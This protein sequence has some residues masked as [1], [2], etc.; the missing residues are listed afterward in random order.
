MHDADPRAPLSVGNGEFAFTA[1]VTG[2][3]SLWRRY[4]G[5]VPL[6]TQS[7][8]GWHSFPAPGGQASDLR[9]ETFDTYGRL[10]GYATSSQG[11][12]TL[13]NW[14]R[15]NPHRLNLGRIALLLDG[16]SLARQDLTDI[17]Q[18]LDLWTG[19]LTS[20]FI[21]Q[22]QP[23]RV[24]TACHPT[25]DA[26]AV[27]ID[28]PLAAS[29]RLAVEFAFPYGSAAMHAS[30]WTA[31][32]KQTTTV[33]HQDRNT[34]AIHRQLD[35]DSYW[36]C[37][38]WN[39]GA[40]AEMRGDHRIVLSGTRLDFTCEFT[41]RPPAAEPVLTDAARHASE[42][43][44]REFWSSG[45]AI[46]LGAST[47]PRAPELERRIVLS[48]YLTAIQCAGST[49]PQETGLTCN[50]W[51]G[52]FHLEMHW[53]HAAHFALW[54]R[55]P[56]LERSLGWYA[57]ILPAA[58]EK[59]KQQGYRGVRWPKMTSPDGRSSPSSIGELLIWQQPHPI[60]LA[61]L[62]YQAHPAR[63]TLERYREIVMESA[64]FM[65]DFAVWRDGRFLL[66]PPLIPAQENH[67]PRET[68]NP[69]FELSYWREALGIAAKW[70]ARLQLPP[71]SKWEQVRTRLAR[72]P[73]VNGVYLA[74]ENCPQ[75]YTA[76]NFDHPSMLAAYGMLSGEGVD[77]ETMRRTLH[78]VMRV[79]R[80][81]ETWGWDF[82]MAA[83]TAIRLGEPETAIDCLFLESP[84]NTWLANGHNWQRA[85]LPVY[86]PGNGALLTAVAMMA[87]SSRGFPKKNWSARCE[88]MRPL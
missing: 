74:H 20:R 76:R 61:E 43:H 82:P 81:A 34:V 51:F 88:G 66:G 32:E 78:K 75:T 53:W 45:G 62:F 40:Q 28:S 10:V 84:K 65:A 38:H 11:Q 60:L 12:E 19:V 31:V 6:C 86:L 69:A 49:P 27:S 21:L 23:V 13:F 24:V 4:E 16:A 46:D 71:Q 73:V 2:L 41:A 58:R 63:E 47:D 50:S 42:T 22:G 85:D 5:T 80:W 67:A 68:W 15:E 79:W 48:Q 18:Q 17:D 35:G 59:A 14:L 33:S 7:Q 37:L 44:W 36:V 70:R 52:K 56:L 1:D 72:L 64:E 29:G 9:L 55:T 3:Q 8:W 87:R 26:L 39:G 54:G 57:S 25:R 30:E 83:L 77:R